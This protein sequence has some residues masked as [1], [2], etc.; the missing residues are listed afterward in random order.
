MIKLTLTTKH[1]SQMIDITNEIKE[2]IIK[3]G[4]KDGICV[5]FS[6]H[7][8][9]GVILFE[10]IDPN[11]QRDFLGHI[12]KLVPQNMPFAHGSNAYAHI[13]SGIVGTSTNLIIKEAKPILGSWQ[14]VFFCEFDGPRKRELY[15]EIIGK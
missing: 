2:E 8:T 11:L 1:K 5:L 3:S 6:P 12:H 9:T 10:N 15:I 13:K 14:G 4:V 7:T